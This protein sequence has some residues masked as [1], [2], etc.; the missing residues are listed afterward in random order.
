MVSGVWTKFIDAYNDKKKLEQVIKAQLPPD[1]RAVFRS[2]LAY[3]NTQGKLED[4]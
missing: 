2:D 3:D 1:R 4:L